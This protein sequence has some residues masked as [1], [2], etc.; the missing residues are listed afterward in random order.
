MPL[1]RQFLP[2]VFAR[3]V[4]A[5]TDSR[6]IAEVKLQKK[7]LSVLLEKRLDFKAGEHAV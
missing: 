2:A 6:L 3:V 1:G 4:L 7:A 5:K